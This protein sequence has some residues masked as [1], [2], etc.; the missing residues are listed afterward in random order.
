MGY[1]YKIS[2]DINDKL[3]IGQTRYS[4]N[5]RFKLHVQDSK[6]KL[7]RP[8]YRAMNKYG[9]EHFTISLIE[10]CPDDQL[11]EREIYWIK[12]LQA[13]SEGYNATTGGEGRTLYDHEAIKER[14]KFYPYALD[15][16]REFNC[17]PD[18][19]REIAHAANIKLISHGQENFQAT[20][21]RITQ[22]SKDLQFLQDFQSVADAARWCYENNYAA[23]CNSGVRSH[24]AEAANHK[25]KSAYGFIWEYNKE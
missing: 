3:Y 25:R 23:T 11:N 5:Y 21:K 24:I 8:L 19:V 17:S 16:A 13:Y 1:I 18:I 22:Y 10:E 12:T 2:N 7:D 6:N 15:V 4:L 9:I 14:L 20:K